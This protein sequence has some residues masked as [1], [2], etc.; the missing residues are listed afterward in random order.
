MDAVVEQR[1]L[2]RSNVSTASSSL[3][4]IVSFAFAL[5][6]EPT[7]HPLFSAVCVANIA[8]NVWFLIPALRK[9]HQARLA[10][11]NLPKKTRFQTAEDRFDELERLKRR[12]MVT[13]EEYA[14]KRQD[15]LKDL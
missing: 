13:P 2:W 10:L 15:I 7:A 14:A 8:L 3:F 5:W 4:V 1:A 11:R 12:Q 6:I 9:A